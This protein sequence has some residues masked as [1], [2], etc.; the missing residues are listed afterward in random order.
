MKHY[1]PFC[2]I[3][4]SNKV[5]ESR[6]HR[7]R[8]RTALFAFVAA[9]LTWGAASAQTPTALSDMPAATQDTLRNAYAAYERKDYAEALRLDQPLAEQGNSLAEFMLGLLYMEGNGVPKDDAR[10]FAW[11][12]KSADQGYAPAEH[13][14]GLLYSAGQGVAHNEAEAAAWFRKAAEQG[15]AGAQAELGGR[16]A[17]G[18]GVPK[19]SAQAASWYRKAADAGNAKAQAGLGLLYYSGDGVQKD[20]AQAVAWYRKSANQGN[21]NGERQLGVMYYYGY[22][23][24]Q[25]YGQAAG[26]FRQAADQGDDDAQVVLGDLYAQ[27][28]G[29]AQSNDEALRWWR[30]AAAQGNETAKQYVADAE[31]IMHENIVANAPPALQFKCYFHSFRPGEE[32][33]FAQTFVSPLFRK[34]IEDNLRQLGMLPGEAPRPHQETFQ[35]FIDRTPPA[36]RVKCYQNIGYSGAAKGQ[37][38]DAYQKLFRDCVA[39][40]GRLVQ[41]R[42]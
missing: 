29:V 22:G 3:A 4:L 6:K 5:S 7:Q 32:R 41:T 1:R 24:P 19:D 12:R 16:Y 2:F 8:L 26:L 38:G 25:D 18:N 13:A 31:K 14:V 34:C 30:K 23:V 39:N 42:R 37:S 9:S 27:G 40:G 10:A 35:E 36:L 17:T 21:V 11:C 28:L 33:N 15:V 20:Y